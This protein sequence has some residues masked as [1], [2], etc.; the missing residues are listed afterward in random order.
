MK[1]SP[2]HNDKGQW[3]KEQHT[4]RNNNNNNIKLELLFKFTQ[5]TT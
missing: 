1:P 4:I 5:Y 3:S 2:D